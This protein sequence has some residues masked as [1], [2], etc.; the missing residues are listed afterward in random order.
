M[1]VR[2]LRVTY[3]PHPSG[4]QADNRKASDP[5]TAAAILQAV[6]GQEAQEVFVILMLDSK[7]RVLGIH[8]VSRGGINE[9]TVDPRIV[10]RAA[11]LV[12]AP[13]I[14]LAHNHP[15]GDTTPSPDDL[16]LTRRM[17]DAG[18]LLGIE[19]LDHLIIGDR[20]YL[21]FRETGRM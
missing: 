10:F 1:R 11:L 19:V 15:S 20:Q 17:I 8:E 18:N 6:L 4:A 5:R 7:H 14:V 12:N 21:S 3:H 16:V 2:E 13:A 9:T